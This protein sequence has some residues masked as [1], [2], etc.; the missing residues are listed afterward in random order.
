V[1]HSSSSS[2]KVAELR[3]MIAVPYFEK[4]LYE[5]PEE[6]LT[7]AS[8]MALADKVRPYNVNRTTHVEPQK[9]RS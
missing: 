1:L 8:L 7:A 3:S 2:Y 6:Q 4:A 5:M 9:L